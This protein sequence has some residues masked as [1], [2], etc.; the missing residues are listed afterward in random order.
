MFGQ[1][2]AHNRSASLREDQV[3]LRFASDSRVSSDNNQVIRRVLQSRPNW[4][5]SLLILELGGIRL[6]EEVAST[7]F[8]PTREGAVRQFRDRIFCKL[9]RVLIAA[10]LEETTQE[11][12]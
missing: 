1:M 12:I 8:E 4:V 5:Q 11:P 2:L 7:D 3:L 9:S 6:V 10:L